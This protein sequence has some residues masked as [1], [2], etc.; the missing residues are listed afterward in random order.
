MDSHGSWTNRLR[1]RMSAAAR[2]LSAGSF[3]RRSASFSKRGNKRPGDGGVDAPAEVGS[4]GDRAAA[5]DALTPGAKSRRCS[6]PDGA[7]EWEREHDVST[8]L[9]F[10]STVA[11]PPPPMSP[12][13][14]ASA[15]E[16]RRSSA[17]APH[18]EVGAGE[19]LGSV[20]EAGALPAL[21]PR[22]AVL[23]EL[24]RT[25]EASGGAFQDDLL[26]ALRR[27]AALC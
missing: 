6:E 27:R 2:E 20:D 11:P 22:R 5:A 21:A 7:S 24:I 15:T 19:E 13:A 9:H 4:A 3:G 14:P 26:L 10:A 12:H 1:L 25:A 23:R 8:L 16:G 18:A 17:P